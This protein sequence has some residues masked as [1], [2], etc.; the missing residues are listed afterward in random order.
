LDNVLRNAIEYSP[1]DS[2]VDVE[3]RQERGEAVLTV[4]DY[5]SGVPDLMLASIFEPFF[6]VDESRESSTGGLGLGLAIVRRTVLL[7]GGSVTASNAKPGLLIAVR[8]QMSESNDDTL[9]G[10]RLKDTLPHETNRV[11]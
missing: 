2:R 8:L 9:S 11:A 6:R 4:R 3:L 1:M 10:G 7:H 5:G